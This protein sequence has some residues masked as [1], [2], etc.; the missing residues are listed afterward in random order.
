MPD[1]L[2]GFG[3]S[4]GHLTEDL[5]DGRQ[6]VVMRGNQLPQAFVRLR[7]GLDQSNSA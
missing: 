5:D 1:F 4:G 7:V 2:L 6:V 3:N